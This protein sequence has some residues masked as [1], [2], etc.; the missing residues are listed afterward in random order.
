MSP[1]RGRHPGTRP[2]RFRRR[3]VIGR[4]RESGPIDDGT[5]DA[6]SSQT[7]TVF[8]HPDLFHEFSFP[9]S[10]DNPMPG[11]PTISR[12]FCAW[13]HN[14]DAHR[15]RGHIVALVCHVLTAAGPPATSAADLEI[16]G[17]S[18]GRTDVGVSRGEL[19]SVRA[20][21]GPARGRDSCGSLPTP[22]PIQRETTDVGPDKRRDPSS[23]YSPGRRRAKQSRPHQ[24]ARHHPSSR[25]TGY[26]AHITSE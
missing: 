12:T 18:E 5:R 9:H 20:G 8:I 7:P 4:G 21:L 25:K 24:R 15:R 17:P 10:R 3:T 22:R 26:R 6:R 1:T 23:P 14:P 19:V 13:V 16:K 11:G 2:S